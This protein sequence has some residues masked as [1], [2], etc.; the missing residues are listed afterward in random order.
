MM[1]ENAP[2]STSKQFESKNI[3]VKLF[4]CEYARAM[5]VMPYAII[6]FACTRG[7][8]IFFFLLT[9]K[10]VIYKRS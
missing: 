5:K 7:Q 8:I 2:V 10:I 6:P 4:L 9:K 1:G 3:R